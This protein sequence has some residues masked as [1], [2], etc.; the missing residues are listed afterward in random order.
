[1]AKIVAPIGWLS[2]ATDELEKVTRKRNNK[3]VALGRKSF[4]PGILSLRFASLVDV[5]VDVV[6][7]SRDSTADPI[8]GRLKV[9]CRSSF[10]REINYIC[11]FSRSVTCART[12]CC[13]RVVAFRCPRRSIGPSIIPD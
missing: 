5:D 6:N 2:G 4:L 13:A 9:E 3:D 12:N 7:H 10:G 8:P 1:M 11:V